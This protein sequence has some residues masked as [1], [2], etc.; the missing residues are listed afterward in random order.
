MNFSFHVDQVI[1]LK[2]LLQDVVLDQQVELRVL[3]IR[4]RVS[5]KSLSGPE[6]AMRD[7]F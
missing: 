2:V 7:A 6:D 4:E 5:I 3:L 1:G